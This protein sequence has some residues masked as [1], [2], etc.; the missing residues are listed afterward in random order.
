MAKKPISIFLILAVFLFGGDEL[1]EIIASYKNEQYW[2]TCNKCSLFI[3]RYQ[4]NSDFLNFCALSCLKADSL[5]KIYPFVKR[6]KNS[7]SDRK[8]SL[9]FLTILYQKE[10]LLNSILDKIDI[11]FVKLPKTNYI[12]SDIFIKYVNKNYTKKD[13]AY[14]FKDDNNPFITY[15][16]TV[17]KIDGENR[18]ILKTFKRD[19]VTKIRVY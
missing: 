18:L 13:N 17:N 5:D 12:L 6:L 4:D 7:P 9:Y 16:L 11:S 14:I 15:K 1:Q 19:I 10:L 2:K 8:N 3:K